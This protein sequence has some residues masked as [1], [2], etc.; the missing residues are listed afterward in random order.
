MDVDAIRHDG[1]MV[2]IGGTLQSYHWSRRAYTPA[3]PARSPPAYNAGF[4]KLQDVMRQLRRQAGE[5]GLELQAGAA[6]A[7]AA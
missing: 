2:L 6:G 4:V 7:G 1:E 3:R 5:A